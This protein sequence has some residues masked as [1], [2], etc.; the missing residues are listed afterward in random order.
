[1]IEAR[2]DVLKAE[3]PV[4]CHHIEGALAFGYDKT[5]LVLRQDV[6]LD[7]VIAGWFKQRTCDEVM[8]LFDEADVVAGPVLDIGDIVKDPQ[9][10]ARENIVS[11]SDVDFGS[12]RMQ[13]V[14]PKFSETPGKVRHAGGRIGTPRMEGTK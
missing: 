10:V 1:M 3:T 12:V 6:A 2:Q 7:E 13:G 8:K 4:A 14:V 11:V 5:R 9:Y